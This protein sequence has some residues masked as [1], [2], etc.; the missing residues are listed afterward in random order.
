V[1]DVGIFL[2][3]FFF[4]FFFFFFYFFFFFFFFF[5]LFSFFGDFF[6]AKK[7]LEKEKKKNFLS[8]NQKS[9]QAFFGKSLFFFGFLGFGKGSSFLFIFFFFKEHLNHLSCLQSFKLNSVL[10][11]SIDSFFFER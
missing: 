8:A 3:F 11:Y 7:N 5:F 9:F 2:V 4:F 1:I 6:G 10:F